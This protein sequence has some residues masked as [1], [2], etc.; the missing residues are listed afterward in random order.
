MP[1]DGLDHYD[2]RSGYNGRPLRRGDE[3]FEECLGTVRLIDS[4]ST[5][6]TG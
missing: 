1:K 3:P 5:E 2:H 4:G 6:A